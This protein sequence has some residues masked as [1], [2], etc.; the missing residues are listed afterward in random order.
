MRLALVF[1]PT[2]ALVAGISWNAD[3]SEGPPRNIKWSTP[4]PGLAHSSLAV[5]GNRIF[6]TTTVSAAGK[7]APKVLV[8]LNAVDG[9]EIWRTSC[10]PIA[11]QSWATA[12]VVRT[13]GTAT[14]SDALAWY[15]PHN[16][17]G[18]TG[19]SASPIAVDGK[20]LF[21]IRGNQ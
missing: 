15:E 20:I 17:G 2:F 7:A 8:L 1:V 9:K 21:A 5:W 16:G 13:Q 6:V 10:E 12:T 18:T 19:F 11:T 3:A 4:I 14:S